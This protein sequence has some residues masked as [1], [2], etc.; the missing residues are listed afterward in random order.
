VSGRADLFA[1]DRAQCDETVRRLAGVD[2]VGRGPLA[3]PVVA[4][5]VRLDPDAPID[6]VDDSKKLSAR[7]RES[8][9]DAITRGA[10]SWAVGSASVEEIDTRNILNASLL[11]MRRA[12]EALEGEWDCALVDGNQYI[13]ALP[14]DRQR[15][16]VRGDAQ[17]AAIAAASI[18]AKVARD[19][20]MTELHRRYPVYGFEDHKGYATARHRQCIIE[21]GLSPAH[22]RTFCSSLMAVQTSLPFEHGAPTERA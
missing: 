19:R 17:S 20:I 15:L 8:L 3:G 4:A 14:R 7:A 9:Y 22:R 5:A 13:P 18:V 11:A 2:E 10:R 12:I 6:G 21:H 16:I 1:F